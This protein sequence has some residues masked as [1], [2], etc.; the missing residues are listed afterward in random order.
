MVDMSDKKE[1]LEGKLEELQEEYSGTK[2]NKATNKH[3]GIL[4]RKIAEV[5]TAIIEAGKSKKGEGFFVK[6]MGDATVALVGFPSAGKSSLINQI[7]R[8][9]SKTAQYAFTTTTIIPGTML[10]KDAHIQVFDMPGLIEGAHMGLGGGRAV[11]S[12][13]KVADLIVFVIDVNNVQQLHTLMAELK[14]LNVRIN[15]Q[16]PRLSIIETDANINIVIEINKSG[17][18]DKDVTMVLNNFGIHHA[19]VKIQEKIEVD[20]FIALVTGKIYYMRAIVALN[21]IDTNRNYQKVASDISSLYKIRVVPIS[22]TAGDNIPELKEEIYK[23]LE[24]MTVYLKPKAG[25]ERLMPM[26]LEKN[27]DVGDAARKFH[28][29]IIDELKCAYITGPSAKFDHQKVGAEHVLKDGDI[30]TF[31][32]NK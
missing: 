12:A 30:V 28:T 15:K 14:A 6:K 32:K 25:E 11:I 29:E 24:I 7:A 1:A 3:L 4:R 5:K 23:A 8:T 13:M 26:I 21:K 27:S 10:Y 20:D 16:R 17:M 19:K 31:I 2:Y 18:S 9:R 22:A